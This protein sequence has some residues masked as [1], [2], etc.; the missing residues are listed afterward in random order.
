MDD[1]RGASEVERLEAAIAALEAQREQLGDAV[2]D[3][4]LAPLG[5]ELRRLAAAPRTRRRQ[6]TV[7]FADLS[8]YTTLSEQLDPEQVASMLAG[9]W[10]HV[11][12]VI[13]QHRGRVFSHMGDGAMAVWGADVSSEDDATTAVDA[14]LAIVDLVET[15]GVV[16]A[17]TRFDAQVSIGINTGL[18]HLVDLQ[19]ATVV[20]DSVN[21]AA[22]LES[23]APA[24][25]VLISRSTFHQVRGI[26][27]VSDRGTL[28]LKG[29]AGAVHAYEV[30]RRRPRTF[31]RPTRGVEG[32]ETAM[33]GRDD[34]LATIVDRHHRVLT[35]FEPCTTLVVGESGVGKSRLLHEAYDWLETCGIHVR[36][37]EGRCR[38]DHPDRAFSLL[39]SIL[40]HRFEINDNDSAE[41]AF[42][43]LATGI[44]GLLGP[45]VDAMLMSGN[46]GGLAGFGTGDSDGSMMR[47]A[48]LADVRALF[49]GFVSGG[50]PAVL[51]VEDIHWADAESLD[52]LEHVVGEA[53]PGLAVLASARPEIASARPAWLDETSPRSHD[54]RVIQL[55]PLDDEQ[56]GRLLDELLQF[57]DTVPDELREQTRQV[58]D[59][60]PFHVE[61][62]V[63]M[64]IDDGVIDVGD[65]WVIHA[66]RLRERRVPT[67]LTGV[68]QARLDLLPADA[69]RVLQVASVI[70]RSFWMEAVRRLIGGTISADGVDTAIAALADAEFVHRPPVS[71]FAGTQQLSFKHEFTR[72]VTYDTVA[73]EDRPA[74]HAAA[75]TWL[76]DIAGDRPAEQAIAIARHLDA[77]ADPTS[78]ASWFERAARHART[79]SAFV[80]AARLF[81]S[82]VARYPSGSAEGHRAAL[83]RADS[84]VVSGQF[85]AAKDELH[86][87]LADG[88]VPG[89]VK[90]RAGAHLA[91]IAFLRDGDFAHAKR[92]LDDAIA[93]PIPDEATSD[94][95]DFVRHQLANLHI[96]V[97]DYPAAVACLE[98]NLARGGHRRD[99]NRHG[100]GLNNL[101]H[102][103]AQDGQF[104]RARAVADEAVAA[105]AELDD[106]RLDMAVRAQLGLIAVVQAD[107]PAARYHF[108]LAQAVNRRN[109]DIEKLATVANFLG[110]IAVELGDLERAREEFAA[111]AEYAIEASVLT[112]LMRSIVG[113]VD[114]LGCWGH[115]DLAARVFATCLAHESAGGEVQR[116]GAAVAAR[117]GFDHPVEPAEVD[118]VAL[119]R[120]LV[121]ATREDAHTVADLLSTNARGALT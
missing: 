90:K 39:R 21:V 102:A 22:R 53:P 29:R 20:G 87:M 100:W 38:P 71:R 82:A 97:G 26:F 64:L 14:A 4:A 13:E 49:E 15:N 8:G 40:S 115:T 105:A 19:D 72:A 55:A 61:E 119:A 45:D 86:G 5:A 101:V 108:D 48:A 106:P 54:H 35:T 27:D 31:H 16:I 88:L 107:W 1:G 9:F 46:I 18:G 98:E 2:V 6:V 77:A 94:A 68:L 17:G 78:A 96:V 113:L 30:L 52:L 34:E 95:H 89:D 7:M 104:D 74:L 37:F 56:I 75:A 57:A 36:Y 47:S 32:I 50:L 81:A 85:D 33:I 92:L 62:L 121:A 117:H 93:I 44:A 24:G 84:L 80:D 91:R 11:D 42:G 28:D 43:K 109:R 23:A 76:T 10:R 116:Y 70:G 41:I 58:C 79:Q 99:R 69:F 112:E 25:A 111:A 60:N 83:A 51:V 103:L 59:G 73:L 3:T 63:K 110:E 114:L 12:A 67:T 118:A 120:A 65:P 66:D